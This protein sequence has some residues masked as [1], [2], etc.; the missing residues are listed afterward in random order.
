M[1]LDFTMFSKH[2]KKRKNKKIKD[3]RG[4]GRIILFLSLPVLSL[5]ASECVA[6]F[7]TCST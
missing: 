4:G 2:E 1:S 3:M 5:A 6:K 7:A